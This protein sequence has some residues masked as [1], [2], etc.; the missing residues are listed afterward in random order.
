MRLMLLWVGQEPLISTAEV[1]AFQ[2]W[3][4]W[5]ENK[6]QVVYPKINSWGKFIPQIKGPHTVD[7]HYN[8]Y[9]VIRWI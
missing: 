2:W 3:E 4:K 1:A 8:M 7:L 6:L 5:S 9:F